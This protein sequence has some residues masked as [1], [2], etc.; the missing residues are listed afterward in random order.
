MERRPRIRIL[1]LHR[2]SSSSSSSNRNR[3]NLPRFTFTCGNPLRVKPASPAQ[4]SRQHHPVRPNPKIDLESDVG[5]AMVLTC[6]APNSRGI[7]SEA[8]S[9]RTPASGASSEHPTTIQVASVLSEHG[10]HDLESSAR[11]PTWSLASAER[12]LYLQARQSRN[13]WIEPWNV[14]DAQFGPKHGEGNSRH[15]STA[16]ASL[17]A[18]ASATAQPCT[19][20]FFFTF[21]GRSVTPDGPLPTCP[22]GRLKRPTRQNRFTTRLT[23]LVGRT[24][25]A[26]S[27]ISSSAGTF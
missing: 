14:T 25:T 11:T 27:W 10:L 9:G 1:V 17:S 24:T 26:R 6:V 18:T 19:F 23:T 7:T 20:S 3:N 13:H 22:S 2:H 12:C 21:F 5:R 4:I 15:T 16:I 8:E